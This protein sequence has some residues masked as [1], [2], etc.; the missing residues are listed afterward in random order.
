MNY[1]SKNQN[2]NS[3]S[4]SEFSSG[5]KGFGSKSKAKKSRNVKSGVQ[6]QEKGGYENSAEPT[7]YG[8]WE[9]AGRCIDF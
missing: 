2:Q 5:S 3:D 6:T 4:E 1:E 9:I 8:D 7:R